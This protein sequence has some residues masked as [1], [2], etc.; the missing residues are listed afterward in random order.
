MWSRSNLDKNQDKRF[1]VLIKGYSLK[2]ESF[3]IFQFT[4]LMTPEFHLTVSWIWNQ[5]GIIIFFMKFHEKEILKVLK[6]F[7]IE[8]QIYFGIT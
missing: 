2:Q 5:M 3:E 6:K 4:N 1:L 7:G 8:V